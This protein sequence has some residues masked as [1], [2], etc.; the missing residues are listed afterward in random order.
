M[1]N[2]G[3]LF[4]ETAG[5]IT[6]IQGQVID[7]HNYKK[8]ILGTNNNNNNNETCR[9]CREETETSLHITEACRQ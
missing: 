3:E 9:K 1:L 7:I 4:P 6:V 2:L 5:F 8:C